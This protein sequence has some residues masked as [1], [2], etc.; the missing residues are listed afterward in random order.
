VAPLYQVH[1]F[2]AAGV[3]ARNDAV[4]AMEPS[5]RGL[6]RLQPW[7]D[8]V[9]DIGCSGVLLTPIFVSSTHGYDTIDPFRIDQRMGDDA[10][11]DAFIAACH[12]H[13]LTLSLDGVFNHVG[14]EFPR[15]VDVLRNGRESRWADW[16]RLDFNRYE[17]KGF[18]YAS[19]EGHRNLVALNHDHPGVLEWAIGV[20]HHWIE[21]GVDGWRLDAAYAMPPA[22]IR[23]LTDVMRAEREDLSVFGEMIHGD[24]A[25]F[26][27]ESGLDGVTQYELHKALWSSF[28]D[29]NMHELSWALARHREMLTTFVPV[30]F[31]GNHD[32]TRIATQLRNPQHLGPI[33]AALCTLPGEPVVYYGDEFAWRGY[34]EQ[35]AGGDDAIRPVLP[36]T[37]EAR[38]AAEADALALHRQLIAVRRDRPWLTSAD[39]EMVD[40]SNRSITYRVTA[41]DHALLV[42]LRVDFDDDRPDADGWNVVALGLG[43]SIFER[44]QP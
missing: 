19:F 14:L 8:H 4:G 36:P 37:A 26:A 44:P 39:L 6:R 42:N 3:A 11:F 23:S 10:D 16:F 27:A 28:N 20:A 31:A 24:Y 35:R 34:K 9:T 18:A 17:G 7:L 43:F 30:T 5:D 2:G 1:A 22:F 33:V 21:R 13:G 40:L 29:A 32:V 25:R 41:D 12:Q 38:S 15:F